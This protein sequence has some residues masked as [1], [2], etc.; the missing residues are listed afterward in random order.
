MKDRRGL[1]SV[2]ALPVAGQPVA[3][4]EDFALVHRF[5]ENG[6]A[7]AFEALFQR[8]QQ[9]IAQLCLSLLRSHAEAEDAV[10]EVFLKAYR[11]LPTYEATVTLRGWLHR[12]AVNHCRDRLAQRAQ[13][14][15]QQ[16]EAA[17]AALAAAPAQEARLIATMTLEAALAR[18]PLDYRVAFILQA[19]EGHSIAETA[20]LLGLS[21]A[22]TASR[23]RRASQQFT[24]AYE[25]LHGKRGTRL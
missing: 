2:P 13:Q 1:R 11:A 5:Q 16:D 25:A 23:L 4:Q 24:R 21:F 9:A 12:I 14:A 3:E 8:H 18:L 19:V 6:E 15:E 17:L 22:A 10:Q 20:D 7:A